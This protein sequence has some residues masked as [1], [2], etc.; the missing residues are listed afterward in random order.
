MRK[1]EPGLKKKKNFQWNRSQSS[2]KSGNLKSWSFEGGQRMVDP[3]N[4]ASIIDEK[5]TNMSQDAQDQH[6]N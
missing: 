4:K 3:H 1:G 5:T 2:N 6:N